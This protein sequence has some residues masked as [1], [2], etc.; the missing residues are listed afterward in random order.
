AQNDMFGYPMSAPVSGS[1][2]FWDSSMS[3]S[4][5]DLDFASHH[6]ATS[7]MLFET[8]ASS[9]QPAEPYDWNATAALFQDP[10]AVASMPPRPSN[11]ENVQPAPRK[12]RPLQPK[13]SMAD[14]ATQPAVTAADTADMAGPYI[15]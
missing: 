4:A 3:M 5:M 9:Q 15:A 14:P 13:P 11:Q 2:S 8:P 10:S 7:G 1:P 6:A 12:N